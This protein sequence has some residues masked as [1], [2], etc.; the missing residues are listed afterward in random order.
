MAAKP[1]KTKTWLEFQEELE[2][3]YQADGLPEAQSSALAREAT[4]YRL[5]VLEAEMI[6]EVSHKKIDQNALVELA[7]A[8]RLSMARG[9]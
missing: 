8:I 9:S 2:A 6:L 1:R 4:I 7:K 5:C 3:D